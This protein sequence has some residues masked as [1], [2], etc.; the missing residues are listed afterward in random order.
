MRI[1]IF[2]LLVSISVCAENWPG[3]RG[4][5]GDGSST[6][7]NLPVKWSAAENVAWKAALP[8]RGHASPIVWQEQVFLVACLPERQERVLLCLDRR[9]GRER[10]RRV[11]IKSPL[12]TIHRLN[13]RASSTPACD[14][15]RVYA[16][17]LKV[18]GRKRV[19]IV[20]D[21][22]ANCRISIIRVAMLVGRAHEHMLMG[23]A[24]KHMLM[25][26]AHELI[27]LAT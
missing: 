7:K 24:R 14:G 17:F 6:E 21:W 15:Q 18:D 4:P 26:R 8:G 2:L 3:W 5:R 10:W 25:G 1:A 11:V 27:G 20:R 12:E 13:S 9:T 16:T 22:A 19:P 23:Q